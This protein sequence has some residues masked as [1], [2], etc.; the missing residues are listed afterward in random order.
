MMGQRGDRGTS[1]VD[2]GENTIV[3]YKHGK[4]RYEIV[5][6]PKRH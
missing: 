6:D 1:R 4:I 2:I 5:V 3:R